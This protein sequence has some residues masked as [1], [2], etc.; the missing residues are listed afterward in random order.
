MWCAGTNPSVTRL[1]Y[2]AVR[3]IKAMQNFVAT[4]LFAKD[5]AVNPLHSVSVTIVT[6][7][8]LVN[9]AQSFFRGTQGLK[10]SIAL[11]LMTGMNLI[12]SNV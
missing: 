1:D 6:T 11:C 8:G 10:R 12:S 4:S 9:I 3:A 2:S 5:D 7:M